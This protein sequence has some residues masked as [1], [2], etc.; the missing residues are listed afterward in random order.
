[1]KRLA[2][3]VLALLSPIL[4]NATINSY[5]NFPPGT[6]PSYS[7]LWWNPSESGWGLSIAHQ[8]DVAFIV[9]YTFERDGSPTW[10]VMP[11]ARLVDDSDM[12]SGMGD[13]EMMMGMSRNPPIF[14]GR[15]YRP[16]MASGRLD[17]NDVGMGTVLLSSQERGAFAYTVDGKAGS[18]KISKMIY[19]ATPPTCTLGGA[20]G[21]TENYQDLWF[22]GF[23]DT[24]WGLNIAHQGNTIFATYYTYDA[25]GAPTWFAMSNT[26]KYDAGAPNTG[27]QGPM[28]RATGPAYDAPWDSSKVNVEVVGGVAFLFDSRGL[29]GMWLRIDGVQHYPKPMQRMTFAAPASVCH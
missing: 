19:S 15:L 27:F 12:V 10:F 1:M 13:V 17:M 5:N 20:K 23:I 3:F 26:D 29:G 7:G 8:G 4:A 24:G 18:K 2:A 9:W 25:K 11:E 14:T 28:I 16:S 6:A 22:G 21:A